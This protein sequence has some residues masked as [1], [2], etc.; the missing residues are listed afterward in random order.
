MRR[1]ALVIDPVTYE[2][3]LHGRPLGLTPTEFRLLHLFAKNE[4]LTLA[5]EMIKRELWADRA[6]ASA[7]LKKYV[8]RLRRKLGDDAKD[9]GWISTVHGVGYRF[10]SRNHPPSMAATP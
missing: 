8:Q 9:P 1:V 5:Q 7:T 6:G 10:N 3:H 2:A 4:Q